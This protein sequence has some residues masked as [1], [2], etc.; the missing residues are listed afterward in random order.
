M[1]NIFFPELSVA[2]VTRKNRP[3]G[4]RFIYGFGKESVYLVDAPTR[5]RGA[6]IAE[7]F[8]GGWNFPNGVCVHIV[9]ARSLSALFKYRLK[10]HG[11][12]LAKPRQLADGRFCALIEVRTHVPMN[13]GVT[14]VQ[15]EDAL[16]AE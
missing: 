11:V 15:A 6:Q 12:W 14:S 8:L 7:R 9:Y 16:E 3:K 2:L 1:V 5:P 10:E 13:I 4:G